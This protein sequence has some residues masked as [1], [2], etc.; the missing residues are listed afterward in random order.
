ME[1]RGLYISILKDEEPQKEEDLKL[2]SL[3]ENP[4]SFSSD[5]LEVLEFVRMI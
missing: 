5:I 3:L 2:V 1:P 4:P